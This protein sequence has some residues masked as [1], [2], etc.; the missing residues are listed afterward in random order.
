M[1]EQGRLTGHSL[2]NGLALVCRLK[3]GYR[4][5]MKGAIECLQAPEPEQTNG[6]VLMAYKVDGSYAYHR[7]ILLYPQKGSVL[8]AR[9]FK[10]ATQTYPADLQDRNTFHLQ[11]WDRHVR[12]T[13]NDVVVIEHRYMPRRLYSTIYRF[14]LGGYYREPG[15]TIRYDELKIRRLNK[16]PDWTYPSNKDSE[17]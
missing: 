7:D 6:G 10:Y 15:A 2:D 12:L 16:R 9:T 3:F 8:A 1:D 5:E 13:V 11:V 4:Y 14:A 17:S